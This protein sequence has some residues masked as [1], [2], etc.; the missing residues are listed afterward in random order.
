MEDFKDK[1]QGFLHKGLEELSENSQEYEVPAIASEG[2]V[3]FPGIEVH[4]VLK[5]KES[6]SAVNAAMR[7]DHVLALIPSPRPVTGT[8]WTL[9]MLKNTGTVVETNLRAEIN[10]MWRIRVKGFSKSS[11][12]LKVQFERAEEPVASGEGESL[13]K[14]VQAEV[15]ESTKLIPEIPKEV[16]SVVGEAKT[17][18]ALADLCA[19]SPQFAHEERLKLLDTLD[20]VQRLKIVSEILEKRL[21]ALTTMAQIKPISECEKCIELADIAF[22][23][24]P[25]KAAEIAISFLNHVVSDHTGELL[26]LLAEKLAPTFLSRRSLR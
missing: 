25:G 10:G 24:D 20:Q 3:L 5:D 22:D 6:L 12:Y 16:L 2:L 21:N 7:R 26:G 23:S 11:G 18:G 19:N 15:A 8:I 4:I 1:E 13:M 14:K 17:P 9:A